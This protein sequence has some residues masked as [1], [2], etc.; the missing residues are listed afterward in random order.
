MRYPLLTDFIIVGHDEEKKTTSELPPHSSNCCKNTEG[1]ELAKS[2]RTH[3][4]Q[5]TK[6]GHQS[7]QIGRQN[8]ANLALS[9]RFH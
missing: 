9:P 7:H 3:D 2:G 6:N 1:S 5:V 4:R 8:D